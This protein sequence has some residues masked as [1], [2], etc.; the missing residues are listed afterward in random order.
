MKGSLKMTNIMAKVR[1]VNDLRNKLLILTLF[2]YSLGK[3]FWKNGDRYE[4]GFKD[5]KFHGKGKK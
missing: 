5:D 2:D 1:D 3:L 4:G